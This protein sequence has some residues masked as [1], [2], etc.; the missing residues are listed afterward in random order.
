M[1][2]YKIKK[3]KTVTDY[4]NYIE[5]MINDDYSINTSITKDITPKWITMLDKPVDSPTRK[6]PTIEHVLHHKTCSG[7]FFFEADE[8]LDRIENYVI[9]CPYCGK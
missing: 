9:L 6:L 1:I 4:K 2:K 7:R 3:F 8:L 5:T